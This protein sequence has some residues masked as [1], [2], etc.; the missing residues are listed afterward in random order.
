MISVTYL[1]IA[2]RHIEMADSQLFRP[3]IKLSIKSHCFCKQ[4]INLLRLIM[5][6]YE[7]LWAFVGIFNSKSDFAFNAFD[8]FCYFTQWLFCFIRKGSNCRESWQVLMLLKK[9]IHP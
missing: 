7:V 5:H 3:T 9:H 1:P 8:H 2:D 6:M 4:A